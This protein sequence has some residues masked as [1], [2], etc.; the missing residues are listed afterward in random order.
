MLTFMFTLW[1]VIFQT[2]NLESAKLQ[3]L[4]AERKL[5]HSQWKA[6]E[7]KKTGVFGHRTKKD[8]VETNDWLQRVILKDNQ[9][10]EELSMKGAID[11]A[12][13]SQEKEDYKSIT[14]KLEREIQILK[15][16]L[17]EKDEEIGRKDSERR[18][19]EW[20]CFLL[21]ISTASLSW[22]IYQLKKASA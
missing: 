7:S 15:R 16:A 8:M 4:I 10:I 17:A 1:L 21:F 19:I 14:V 22:W 18:T 20:T 9:I 12:S 11:K 6:S 5:L 2:E 3:Q 13:I